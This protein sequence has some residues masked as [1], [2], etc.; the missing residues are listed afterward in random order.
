MINACI[1][2]TILDDLTRD[3]T[4]RAITNALEAYG[5]KVLVW[6]SLPCA[7][8]CPYANVNAGGNQKAKQRLGD[9][10]S[11]FNVLWRAAT[12]LMCSARELGVVIAFEWPTFCAYWKRVEVKY[13]MEVMNYMFLQLHGCM[14]G[15]RSIARSTKRRPIKKPWTIATDCPT[16]SKYLQKKCRTL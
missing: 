1:R 8:G 13:Q 10:L 11:L 9:H 5:D 15:L 7:G 12:Q 14:Y 16:L 2:V 3:E 4:V 6:F